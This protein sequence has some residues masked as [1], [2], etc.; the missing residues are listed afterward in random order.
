[1]AYFL[2]YK[3]DR[4]EDQKVRK[5][6]FST[7]PEAV[8][9]ACTVI[10]EGS[11]WNSKSKTMP[12]MSCSTRRKSAIDARARACHSG[13]ATRRRKMADEARDEVAAAWW[14][15]YLDGVN[16]SITA[17]EEHLR[18]SEAFPCRP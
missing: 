13:S 9:M 5:L 2:I 3:Y 14:N 15:S 7:E 8:I 12:A 6:A 16:K 17:A 10:A 4:N 11:G 18:D 1:M